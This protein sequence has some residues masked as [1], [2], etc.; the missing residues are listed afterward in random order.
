MKTVSL[1]GAFFALLRSTTFSLANDPDDDIGSVKGTVVDQT[2]QPDAY[3]AI[4]IKS[5]DGKQT[6][7]G[8]ISL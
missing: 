5:K 1:L 8:G 6:I 2:K 3:A 4:V 7:T